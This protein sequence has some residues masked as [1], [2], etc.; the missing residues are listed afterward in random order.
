MWDWN[1]RGGSKWLSGVCSKHTATSAFCLSADYQA[2][3]ETKTG[4]QKVAVGVLFQ[5]YLF[6]N[7][8]D[9]IFEKQ[10]KV[11]LYAFIIRPKNENKKLH[12]DIHKQTLNT[13]HKRI[14]KKKI[15]A[16]IWKGLPRKMNHAKIYTEKIYNK[17]AKK[18]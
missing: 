16:C 7:I 17:Y 13:N 18:T 9:Y 5:F 4:I 2:R 10:V 1:P 3:S 15:R 14:K 12:R 6:L 11:R 8:S